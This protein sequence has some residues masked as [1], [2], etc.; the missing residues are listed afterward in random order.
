MREKLV[1]VY[2][3]LGSNLGARQANL[4]RAIERLA[5]KL[6]IEQASSIYETEPVSYRQQPTFLN[7][8]CRAATELSPCK[9]L[10]LAKEIEDALGRI[11]SFRNGPRIIDIDILLYGTQVMKTRHLTIPHPRLTERAFVLVPLAEI[12]PQL[13][14]PTLHATIG[15]LAARVNG[16]SGVR[17]IGPW[18]AQSNRR[19]LDPRVS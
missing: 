13:V 19:Q 17:K 8:V 16:L 5:E 18:Q 4:K 6:K 1:T 15:E 7:V 2:L 11:P 3:G 14:H 9:L 12:A 10:H